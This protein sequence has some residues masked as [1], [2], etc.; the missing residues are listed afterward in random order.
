[1]SR[2]P[3]HGTL[4][5]ISNRHADTRGSA[6]CSRVAG[7]PGA[8]MHIGRGRSGPQDRTMNQCVCVLIGR[9]AQGATAV[10]VRHGEL[11]IAWCS[12]EAANDRQPCVGRGRHPE[13]SQRA[14]R[15]SQ[16][17]WRGRLMTSTIGQKLRCGCLCGR[18]LWPGVGD[19]NL[20]SLAEVQARVQSW[21]G[22]VLV[23]TLTS[24]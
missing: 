19:G 11:R 3:P 20:G 7:I 17:G 9:A 13:V 2:A 6:K 14:T 12:M 5:L 15:W 18:A 16:D 24:R 21:S 22:A 4:N 23:H 8:P 1:M 10:T